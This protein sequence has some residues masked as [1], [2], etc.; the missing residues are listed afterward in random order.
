MNEF[1]DAF[2]MQCTSVVTEKSMYMQRNYGTYVLRI[3]RLNDL[4]ELR[5]YSSFS[6]TNKD[7][8]GTIHQYLKRQW[9]GFASL[10]HTVE[11]FTQ[12]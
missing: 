3:P 4:R 11:V 7:D 10:S 8:W 6:N 1:L 5:G 9:W 12:L 2:H